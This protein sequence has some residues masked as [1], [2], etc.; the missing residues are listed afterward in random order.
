MRT[1]SIT[2]VQDA[3]IGLAGPIYGL[4]AALVSL[5]AFAVTRHPIFGV[6]PAHFGAI[7]NLFNL[8]PVWQ[9][10]GSR[11]FHSLTRAQRTMI[12]A[13]A[14]TLAVLFHQGMLFLI[15]IGAAYRLFTKDSAQ[16]TDRTCLMQYVMLMVALSVVAAWSPLK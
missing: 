12:L 4:G 5:I 16:E 15:G 9:L 14:L 3:R 6:I 10:D 11:A 1:L 8:I 7:I 2:P 13:V